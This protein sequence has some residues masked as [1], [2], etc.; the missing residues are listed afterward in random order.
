MQAEIE[1]TEIELYIT[2]EEVLKASKRVKD[3]SGPDK[4]LVEPLK[5][6]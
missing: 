3:T 4:I 6:L 2:K 1:E 5:L